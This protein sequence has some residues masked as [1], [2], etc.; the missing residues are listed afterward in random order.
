MWLIPALEEH[1]APRD[2]T[3]ARVTCDTLDVHIRQFAEQ[4]NA[5]EQGR[6][7]E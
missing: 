6:D 5:V 2:V 3:V 4:R 7:V 1:F